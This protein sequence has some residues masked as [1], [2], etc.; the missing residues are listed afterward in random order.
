MKMFGF[1]NMRKF[2]HVM[3]VSGNAVGGGSITYANV[4]LKPNDSIWSEGSWA[5]LADWKR[6]MPQ[7]YAT[8]EKMLGVT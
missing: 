6:I 2:R 3:I 8:A 5:G 4:L 1:Y 7:H